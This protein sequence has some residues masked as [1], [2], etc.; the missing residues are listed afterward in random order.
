MHTVSAKLAPTLVPESQLL[1]PPS[2]AGEDRLL[3]SIYGQDTSLATFEPGHQA[4]AQ[5]Q[6]YLK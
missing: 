1:T 3:A 6:I 4:E 5:S 2:T